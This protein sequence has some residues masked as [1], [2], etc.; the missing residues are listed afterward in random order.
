VGDLSM[1]RLADRPIAFNPSFTLAG[2]V[3]DTVTM[4]SAQKDLVTV[5]NRYHPDRPMHAE[6]FHCSQAS[7]VLALVRSRNS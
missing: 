6:D 7:K 5:K 1:L 3:G 2:A 4:V